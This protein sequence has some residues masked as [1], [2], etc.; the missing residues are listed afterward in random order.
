MQ[1][2][3]KLSI[4]LNKIADSFQTG[5]PYTLIVG[6]GTATIILPSFALAIGSIASITTS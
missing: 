4:L 6:L 1:I 3:M 5:K 2:Y